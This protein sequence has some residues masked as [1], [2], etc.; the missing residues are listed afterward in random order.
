MDRDKQRL[1][2]LFVPPGDRPEPRLAKQLLECC[3]CHGVVTTSELMNDRRLVRALLRETQSEV[4]LIAVPTPNLLSGVRTLTDD[5]GAVRMMI[6]CS[7]F[8]R[9]VVAHR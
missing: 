3:E 7:P 9:G 4:V 6:W 5:P 8:D 2:E 1:K